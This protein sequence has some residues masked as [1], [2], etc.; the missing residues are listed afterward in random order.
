M[1]TQ[2]PFTIVDL[3]TVSIWADELLSTAFQVLVELRLVLERTSAIG[4]CAVESTVNWNHRLQRHLE[5]RISPK[6]SLRIH[7]RTRGKEA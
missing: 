6:V 7:F 3:A 1:P 5:N 2:I 4:V